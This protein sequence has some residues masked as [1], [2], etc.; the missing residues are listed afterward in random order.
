LS[1]GRLRDQFCWFI[2]STP[3]DGKNGSTMAN[4]LLLSVVKNSYI[5]PIRF[6]K[7]ITW[8][9]QKSDGILSHGH[10]NGGAYTP[11][12]TVDTLLPIMPATS[13]TGK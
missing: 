3:L 4:V 5:N 1:G 13:S 11:A 9:K 12:Y 10:T 8:C 6:G 2:K 7:K